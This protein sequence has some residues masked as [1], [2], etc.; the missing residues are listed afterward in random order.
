MAKIWIDNFKIRR[1]NDYYGKHHPYLCNIPDYISCFSLLVNHSYR[2]NFMTSVT[3][4]V[5][6]TNWAKNWLILKDSQKL[7]KIYFI[8]LRAVSVSIKFNVVKYYVRKEWKLILSAHCMTHY[9]LFCEILQYISANT[10]M[11]YRNCPL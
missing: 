6:V 3:I 8:N 11:T 10:I 4:K 9:S 7:V 2:A 1:R 5:Q